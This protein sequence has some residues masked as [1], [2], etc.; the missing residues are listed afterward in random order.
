MRIKSLLIAAGA[1]ATTVLIFGCGA[2]TPP[3]A[4]KTPFQTVLTTKQLMDWV[5]DPQADIVWASVAT[6]ITEAGT[7]E[8]APKTDEEWAA[9][10][11]AAATVAEAGNLLML[12]G[13]AVDQ[14]DWMQKTQA[15]IDAAKVVLTAIEAKDAPA[16]FTAGSD[17]YLTCSGC[18]SAYIFG[19]EGEAQ[20][21]DQPA[22]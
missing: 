5:F 12:E 21:A 15:M 22:K 11:N 10:R 8:I 6:I 3:P 16:V 2:S 14:A 7:E 19:G 9:I 18:H 13:R 4:A 1:L 17:L 20:P